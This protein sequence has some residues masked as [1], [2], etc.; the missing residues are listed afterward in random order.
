MV[1][2][3]LMIHLAVT[4][5]LLHDMDASLGTRL[6]KTEFESCRMAESILSGAWNGQKGR[7]SIFIQTGWENQI[8]V[9]TALP[10][11]AVRHFEVGNLVGIEE[12]DRPTVRSYTK[13]HQ[14]LKEVT[15]KVSVEINNLEEND[16]LCVANPVTLVD[17]RVQIVD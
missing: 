16:K 9:E 4:S 11:T 7:K 10:K 2:C 14:Y 3:I 13:V 8:L 17:V 6:E 15:V 1:G 5:F 12:R